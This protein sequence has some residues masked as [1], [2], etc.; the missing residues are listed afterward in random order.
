MHLE[1]APGDAGDLVMRI[2]AIL[3][4]QYSL[5]E[6][7]SLQKKYS[8]QEQLCRCFGCKCIYWLLP[9]GDNQVTVRTRQQ[10]AVAMQI[11]CCSDG[12]S[13]AEPKYERGHLIREWFAVSSIAAL[14]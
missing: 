8:L 4:V 10:Y 12:R 9:T 6:K 5:Q 7:Y 11:G 13:D 1:G 14:A 3:Q 2:L